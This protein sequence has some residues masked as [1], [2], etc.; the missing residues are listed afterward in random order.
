MTQLGSAD[1]INFVLIRVCTLLK[2]GDKYLHCQN[3]AG[4]LSIK[5]I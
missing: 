5:Y 1:M 3:V 2:V 4:T